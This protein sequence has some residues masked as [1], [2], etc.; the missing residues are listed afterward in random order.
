MSGFDCHVHIVDPARHPLPADAPRVP[1]P[2]E[3]A[4]AGDLDRT[5][6]QAGLTA[7]LLVQPSPY[8]DDNAALLGAL[9]HAGGRHRAIAALSP[10]MDEATLDT[11]AAAGVVGVRLNLVNFDLRDLAGPALC[12]FLERLSARDW[13]VEL[14]CRAPAFPEVVP[15][16]APSGVRILFDHCGYPD[17]PLG[18]DEPGFRA[19]LRHAETGRAA[20]KLSGAFRLS[21]APYPHPDLDPFVAAVLAAFGT[22]RCVWG[23]DYPFI[24]AV[25]R[26]SHAASL[27]MLA[28]WLPDPAARQ[29]VMVDA[30]VRLFGF[31]RP[32][33]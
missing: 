25:R 2:A 5:L 10:R 7:A 33:R 3:H 30:P 9:A 1:D 6:A 27:A 12:A 16:L 4:S 8:R 26:P 23:S 22:D 20:I 31:D 18:P 11:L 14:Q 13:W 24:F 15:L 21:M 17:L 28:R 19:I 32:E 29:T